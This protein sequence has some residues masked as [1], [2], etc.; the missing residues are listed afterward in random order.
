MI[1]DYYQVFYGKVAEKTATLNKEQAKN[2]AEGLAYRIPSLLSARDKDG[3]ETVIALADFSQSGGDFGRIQV[4]MRI[5]ED[6]GKTFGDMKTVFSLP[7]SKTPQIDKDY[8]SAFAIDPILGQHPNGDVLMIVDMFPESKAIMHKPWLEKGSGFTKIDGKDYLTL[9]TKKTKVGDGKSGKNDEVYTVR[10]N[11]WIYTPDGK[12]TR[13]YLPQNHSYENAF[14]T[15]GDMYYA[16]GEGE[17][18]D[19]YPPM[20]PTEENTTDI[21][22][23]NVYLSENKPAF[24]LNNPVRVTKREVGPDKEGDLKSAYYCV[25]TSPAPISVLPSMHL[26]VLRSKD[27]GRTWENPVDISAS[28]KYDDEI[29]IG[30]GP[31]VA[32]VLHNQKD[33]KKN[34]RILAPIYNLKETYVVYSDDCGKTWKRSSASHNIDETQLIEAEDG[35]LFCFGRQKKLTKTP[36]SVSFDGGE[37]WQK[38]KATH[39]SA[40]RCQKSFLLLPPDSEVAYPEGMD[41]SKRYVVSSVPS[42]NYQTQSVRRGGMLTLGEI[43]GSEIKW[44]KQQKIITEGVTGKDENFYAYSSLTNMKNGEIGILYE[45]CPAGFILF[46]TFTLD[47][48]WKGEKA[49]SFP[50][51]LKVRLKNL[52]NK[53]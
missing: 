20:M 23:G 9:H 26:F 27:C 10:E 36:F 49:F 6:G 35:T 8:K 38:Q 53:W 17:F 44:L 15:L 28:V 46:R 13:Y 2:S 16:V 37:T 7:V 50:M 18:I 11:G 22:V 34:G 47:W 1:K 48:L 31:G 3:N 29:F 14:E 21:Y 39:L 41:K 12:K 42:G 4:M 30:T 40:V 52:F 32:T 51:P 5:S 33:E 25:E 43:N 24:D 19:K 45:A